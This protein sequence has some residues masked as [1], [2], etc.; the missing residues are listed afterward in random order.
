MKE[1]NKSSVL[2]VDDENA[3]IITLTHILSPEFKIFAAK[4]GRDAIETAK[5]YLPDVI[6]LDIL[7]PEM[8]GYEVI[9]LLKNTEEVKS[10]PVIFVTWLANSA[11]EE[12][13]LSK[14]AADYITKPFIPAIVRLRVQN[15]IK[16]LRQI[17]MNNQQL[18][19]QTLIASISQSFLSGSGIDAL[20]TN[21]LRIIGE[22]MGIAK[23]LLLN[24]DEDG[25]TFTC[26]H[27]WINP[28]LYLNTSIG[29]KSVMKEPMLSI[30]SNLSTGGSNLYLDSNDPSIKEAMS[31]YGMDSLNY[32]ITPIFNKGKI[33]AAICFSREDNDDDDWSEGDINLAVII[34][35]ILSGVYERTAM[36]RQFS[37][38][39]N[40][41]H[42]IVYFTPDGDMSY[43]NP[44][45][46]KMTGCSRTE[47]MASGLELIFSP[48]TVKHLKETHIPNALRCG[49]ADFEANLKRKNNEERILYFSSFPTGD[50]NIAAIAQDLTEMYKLYS[51]LVS[52]K[53]IAEQNSRAKSEFL[54]RMSHEMHTPMYVVIGMSNIA[55]NTDD[56]A[57]IADCLEKINNASRHLLF[58][59]EDMLDIY[60]LE[61]KKLSLDNSEFSF[62]LM[63]SNVLKTV[64]NFMDEKHQT[65]SCYID[66]SIPEA[67]FCD[68][69]RLSQVIHNLL[70]NANK[71]TPE[72]GAI[73][74]KA[75]VSDAEKGLLIM[76][77]EVIDSGI[78]IPKEKQS[79]VFEPFEQ[80]DGGFTR[81][82]GGV[83]LG[84]P[85]S[86]KIVE[87]MGGEIWVESEIDKGTKITFTFKA[88]SR[89]S[90]DSKEDF[91]SERIMISSGAAPEDK[92]NRTFEGKAALLVDDMEINREILMAVLEDT[93]IQIDCAENGLEA[94]ELF[95]SNPKRY[96]MI[97]MD[98]NMPVMDGWEA[99]RRI[100]ALDASAG[101][102]VPIVAL[103]ANKLPEDVKKC[104]DVGMND[105]IGKPVDFELL[106]RKLCQYIKN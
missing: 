7:M 76:K 55:K 48:A 17:E 57:V 6:L 22:F 66:A 93:Q 47:I 42:F 71:F 95:K 84:L 73:Q 82:Y 46:V 21:T 50:G 13:G 3:N 20:L 96:D 25:K 28:S 5:K 99:T 101:K 85:I 87:M 8:D 105:H 62:S 94:V 51:E 34:S 65:F 106:F 33:C 68:E 19:Q 80:V 31:P 88:E 40:S 30:I 16:M 32:I 58:L 24:F 39:E 86:R 23:I 83:G 78:G 64:K 70:M 102:S 69:H 1:A 77:I 43:I 59:L 63:L 35:N 15:Q 61:K 4:N 81:K 10:I 104:F 37:I 79:T 53:E 92:S 75:S 98:I 11:H 18:K 54:S 56:T 89:A 36:E 90:E 26:Q 41:P 27:E 45:A 9:S 74:L 103:T 60:A 29:G 38:V 49:H 72:H 14:G 97:L 44:A 91:K 2:I 12:K 67:L 100:R 52:A